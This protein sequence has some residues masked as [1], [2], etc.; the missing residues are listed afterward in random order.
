MVAR[1]VLRVIGCI[2]GGAAALC[3]VIFRIL[4]KS[5]PE[6]CMT[7]C[8][9]ARITSIV[10]FALAVVIVVYDLITKFPITSSLAG[11]GMSALGFIGQFLIAPASNLLSLMTFQLAHVKPDGLHYDSFQLE[12]GS[13]LIILAGVAT[14]SYHAKNMKSG[15]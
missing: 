11:L 7:M 1:N 3:A 8:V 10:L 2:A 13:Y 5:S 4:L 6:N 12:I 15:T 14:I 9:I